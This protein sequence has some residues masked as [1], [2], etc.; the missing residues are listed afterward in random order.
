MRGLV[1]TPEH[2]GKTGRVVNFDQSRSR[3]EV[4]VQGGHT[5]SLRPQN[6]TQQCEI[7]VTGLENKPELNGKRGDIVNYDEESGRYAV[8]L[9]QPPIACSLQRA[10]CLLK[11]GT[12]VVIQGLSNEKFN[13]LMARII[14]VDRSAE[15]YTVKC[16]TGEQIK[17]KYDKAL[18]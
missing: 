9:Q 7:E 15:R 16:E 1:K 4:T 10:N 3:Y 8:L 11:E 12:R 2:N 13:G 18:C 6:L 17:I 14:E 5:L